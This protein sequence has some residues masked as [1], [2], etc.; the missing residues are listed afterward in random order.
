MEAF[1]A[2]ERVTLLRGAGPGSGGAGSGHPVPGPDR[3]LRRASWRRTGPWSTQGR[4]ADEVLT[5]ILKESGYL[6]ELTASAD[7]QDQTRVEN[8]VEL[9]AVAGE[10]VAAAHAVDLPADGSDG[11]A[12]AA[13]EPDDSLP[14]FLERIAL[15]ADSD[16]IPDADPDAAGVVTLMTLH[17][18]KGLEF[19]TV[20]LTGFEDGIFPHQRA[21]LDRRGAGGGTA[22]RL[23]RDHPR[24]P[25]PVPD[26]GDG[27]IGLG[28][29][30]VQPGEPVH[31]RDPQPP[32]RLAASRG[33]PVGVGLL[34]RSTTPSRR[35]VRR[36]ATDRVRRSGPWPRSSW[37]TGCCTPPSAWGR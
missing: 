1:A 3:E 31:R 27:S 35:G 30:A 37:G 5:S 11:V 18:A 25:A 2:A 13:P 29:A 17:T 15:V 6:A 12:A 16:Q 4:P 19:Q 26:P 34:G 9:V 21:M 23:C 8:L 7:P 14:A 24:P 33:G 32:D 20:F 36:S 28:P 10:F 22:P